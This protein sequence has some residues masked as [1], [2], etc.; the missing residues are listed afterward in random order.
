MWYKSNTSW[1]QQCCIVKRK[2]FALLEL[3]LKVFLF[4]WLIYCLCLY[5]VHK[6]IKKL[7]LNWYWMR[8][9]PKVILDNTSCL[10]WSDL[11]HR[12]CSIFLFLLNNKLRGTLVIHCFQLKTLIV[13]YIFVMIKG[14]EDIIWE[15]WQKVND[16][17][18]LKVIDTDDSWITYNLP[19]R[20]NICGVE[21]EDNI[22]EEYHID[23]RVDH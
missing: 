10:A 7:V 23:N 8:P 18:R 11:Y 2:L 21:V 6:C 4:S 22:N 14:I 19:S 12:K 15:A 20:S 16:E 13:T 3:F 17:P 5:C 1:Q 9:S